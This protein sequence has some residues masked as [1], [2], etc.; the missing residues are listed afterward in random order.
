MID[1]MGYGIGFME[2]FAARRNEAIA[3]QIERNPRLAEIDQHIA[4]CQARGKAARLRASQ[5][6]RESDV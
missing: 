2:G 4:D 6:M 5:L 1:D 3:Q